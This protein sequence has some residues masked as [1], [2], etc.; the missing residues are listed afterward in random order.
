MRFLAALL[1]LAACSSSA[2]DNP[3]DTAPRWCP[4]ID[5]DSGQRYYMPCDP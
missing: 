2:N 5:E 1:L 3:T 4:Q